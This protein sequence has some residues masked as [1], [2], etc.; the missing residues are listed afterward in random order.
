MSDYD[1]ADPSLRELSETLVKLAREAEGLMR[2]SRLVH[3]L[4]NA[5]KDER[6]WVAFT[7]R[8]IEDPRY[9]IGATLLSIRSVQ[10]RCSDLAVLVEMA[11]EQRPKRPK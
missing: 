10:K 7:P 8:S 4:A 3:R 2:D 9:N 5:L 1:P 6:N 11:D